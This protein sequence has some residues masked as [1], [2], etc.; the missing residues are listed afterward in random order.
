[1]KNKIKLTEQDIDNVINNKKVI[2]KENKEN[3]EF[4]YEQ[5]LQEKYLGDKLLKKI[6]DSKY[7]QDLPLVDRTRLVGPDGNF[8]LSDAQRAINTPEFKSGAITGA[9]GG[10]LA[11]VGASAA[12][13]GAAYIANKIIKHI[14]NKFKTKQAR[15]EDIKVEGYTL[16]NKLKDID[17]KQKCR[18]KVDKLYNSLET[19]DN[20]Q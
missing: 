17:M 8:E 6:S 11:G 13:G 2:V 7:I 10:A 4:T 14:K 19:Y 12:I 5:F 18:D 16:C 1:M 20:Q 15:R 9:A 3:K